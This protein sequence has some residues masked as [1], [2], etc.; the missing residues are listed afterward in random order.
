MKKVVFLCFAMFLAAGQLH[1]ADQKVMGE[2]P[3]A[4]APVLT[5]GDTWTIDGWQFESPFTSTFIGEESGLLVFDIGKG[6]K[7]YKSKDHNSVKDIKNGEVKNTRIPDMGFLR[8]PLS[9]GKNWTHPYQ[10]D[11]IPRTANYRVIAY[12]KVTVRAGTFDAPC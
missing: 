3:S 11:G 5:L 8:S 10:N 1:A 9:I 12:E 4:E 7:R 6:G 2:S